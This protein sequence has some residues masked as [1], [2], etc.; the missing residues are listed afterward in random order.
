MVIYS[1]LTRRDAFQLAH[2][3]HM[4]YRD[5]FPLF[6]QVHATITDFHIK[7]HPSVQKYVK[8]ITKLTI[9]Y[10]DFSACLL[11]PHL[12]TLHI[13]TD[14]IDMQM[15]PNSL[16][17]LRFNANFDAKIK[18][19][20]LPPHL[21]YLFFYYATTR[22]EIGSLPNSLQVLNFKWRHNYEFEKGVLPSSL[23]VLHCSRQ[24]NQEWKLNVLPSSLLE[25]HCGHDYDQVIHPGCLPSLLTKLDLDGIYDQ[26][27]LEGSLPNSVTNLRLGYRYNQPF[28]SLP[29]SLTELKCGASYNQPFPCFPQGLKI[30]NCGSSFTCVLTDL[31]SSLVSLTVGKHYIH[32]LSLPQHVCELVVGKTYPYVNT[33]S[34]KINISCWM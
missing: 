9:N 33:I 16:T 19:N 26:P 29:S 18:K 8:Y 32:P 6:L 5:Y 34:K 23:T 4:L 7:Y 1:F 14:F 13:N 3:N 12:T 30:L 28:P 25:L 20:S 17:S 31:P 15:L 22:L 10:A 11:F 2:V 27:F 21:K 24:Y